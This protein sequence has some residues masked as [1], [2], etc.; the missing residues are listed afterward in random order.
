MLAR[1]WVPSRPVRVPC[2]AG[3]KRPS[4]S[5]ALLAAGLA[6]RPKRRPL[7]VT[8]DERTRSF[9]RDL[10]ERLEALSAQELIEVRSIMCNLD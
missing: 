1:F 8:K 6:A 3:P 5:Q 2:Q 4:M 7:E 9:A 10:T